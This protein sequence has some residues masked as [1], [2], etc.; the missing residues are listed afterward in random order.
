MM[1]LLEFVFRGFWTFL[2]FVVLFTTV[3]NFILDIFK[4]EVKKYY[5]DEKGNET[6]IETRKGIRLWKEI[7][8]R[9]QKNKKN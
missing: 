1:E 3:V 5:T 7:L 4:V 6:L 2:G 9:S 8:K